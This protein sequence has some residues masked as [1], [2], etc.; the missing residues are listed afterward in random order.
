MPGCRSRVLCDSTSRL[1]LERAR[2]LVLA[3]VLTPS[4]AMALVSA[5]SKR[6]FTRELAL[7]PAD[8]EAKNTYV[9]LRRKQKA[10]FIKASL[11]IHA[12]SNVCT[13]P[14]QAWTRDPT[15]SFVSIFKSHVESWGSQRLTT[16]C[17][18]EQRET[19]LQAA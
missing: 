14:I 1:Q 9:S 5:N 4:N 11:R 3:C 19:L 13:R 12:T 6:T 16:R 2:L 7:L 17:C 15:W 18:A 10:E 8:A